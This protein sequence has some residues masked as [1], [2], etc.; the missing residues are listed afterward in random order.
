MEIRY[1]PEKRRTVAYVDGQEVGECTYQEKDALW[2]LN[3]TYVDERM[4]GQQLASKLV[5][6]LIKAARQ[7]NV[8]VRPVCSF[9]QKEFERRHE[10]QDLLE[11]WYGSRSDTSFEM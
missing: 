10:Y 6:E 2:I 4:R 7:A 1:E 3:H 9:V 8:K 11:N 5:E